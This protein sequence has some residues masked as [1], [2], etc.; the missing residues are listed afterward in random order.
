MP[1]QTYQI[2]PFTNEHIAPAA[3]ILA[4][5][6]ASLRSAYP[7]LPE[8]VADES[9]AREFLAALMQKETCQGVTLFDNEKLCGYMVGYSDTN[10][11]F[12]EYGWVPF[13]GVALP[14]G[15]IQHALPALYAA[16]GE[17]WVSAGIMNHYLF[18]PALEAWQRVCASLSFGQQQ[19]YALADLTLQ[20]EV[21]PLP[22]G[23]T[24]RAVQPTDAQQLKDNAH[25]IAARL[26]RAPVWAPV[27]AEHLAAIREGYAELAEEE[28]TITWLAFYEDEM[29]AFMVVSAEE[30]GAAHYLA[31]Q[32]SAHFSVAAV[33]PDFRG[34]GIGR[35]LFTHVLEITRQR[36]F[37]HVYTDWRT[38]NLEANSYWPSFGFTPF[39]FRMIRRVNPRYQRF[40][41]SEPT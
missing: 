29:T 26:N 11:F 40:E 6:S 16:L 37:T 27:P 9:V 17:K 31:S 3:Q 34:R 20:R 41:N 35:A 14:D 8:R 24:M 12:G 4:A 25:W 19:A 18:C 28:E 1:K 33:H 32:E 23:F 38:T 21:P 2:V 30:M 13:G 5:Q 10:P 36:G 22:A 15:D 39:A 7:L